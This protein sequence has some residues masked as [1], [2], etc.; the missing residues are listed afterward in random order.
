[1][2]F[3]REKLEAFTRW[4]TER[5]TRVGG[6]TEITV[7]QEK[8]VYSGYFDGGHVTELI[9]EIKPVKR[10]KVPYGDHPRIGE[11]N[12]YVSA[13]AVHPDLLSLANNRIKRADRRFVDSRT[14]RRTEAA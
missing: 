2:E 14:D 10:T 7:L 12:V 13:Q 3:Q 9:E 8:A 1:M 5:H 4:I 6:V 11:G